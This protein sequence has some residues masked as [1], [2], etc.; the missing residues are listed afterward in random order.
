[1][2]FTFVIIGWRSDQ[3]L[4]ILDL[5]MYIK[6]ELSD[7]YLRVIMYWVHECQEK[8]I[9]PIPGCSKFYLVNSFGE[10]LVDTVC[11]C[12]HLKR[13]RSWTLKCVSQDSHSSKFQQVLHV[14]LFIA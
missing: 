6:F 11:V 3:N 2:A 13:E 9:I 10:R 7:F 12:R 1:M 4:N 14:L 8:S 5:S